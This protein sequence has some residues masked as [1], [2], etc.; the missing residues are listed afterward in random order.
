M[1]RRYG[2]KFYMIIEDRCINEPYRH[3]GD[4]SI[5]NGGKPQGRRITLVG[6]YLPYATRFGG[7]YIDEYVKDRCTQF[8]L[9]ISYGPHPP[10]SIINVT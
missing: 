3:R 10:T 1:I 4:R 6:T 9:T 2:V 5:M 7:I 8:Q